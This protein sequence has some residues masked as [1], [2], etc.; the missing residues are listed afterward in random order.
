MNSR[1]RA[2]A[3]LKGLPVD[4]VP[5]FYWLNPHATCQMIAE[6]QPA[7]S[8]VANWLARRL[9]RRFKKQ[10][11]LD[12]GEWTRAW[13]LLFEE[14]GN[15]QYALQLGADVSIQ[16]P[17]LSSPTTFVTSVRKRGGRLTF[18]GPFDVT[19][20]MGGVY[21]FPLEP[22]VADARNLRH[23]E[24]PSITDAQFAGVRR[25]RNTHLDV[26]VAC[27]VFAFQ[28]VLCDY[29]LAMEPF[30]LALYDYP[31]EIAAFLGRL[32]DWVV[33]IIQH[34]ARTGADVLCFA[35]DYG[36]TGRP[37]ISMEMWK[38]FTYP[39]LKRF[40]AVAHEEGVPFMLHS[41]G[42]QMP[43]LEYYVEAELD[44]LQSF[45]PKAGND[46]AAAYAQYGDRLAFATGIDIQRGET[47]TPEELRQEILD[48]YAIGKSKGRFILGTTHMLQ[49][50]MPMENLQAIFR[51]VQE[52]QA[53]LHG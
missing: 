50:S 14:Y 45:Q 49:Y 28:Q 6:Y 34:A 10:G 19:L 43:F 3:A 46:L 15:G 29:I 1:E 7:H 38:T 9:W 51:T 2:L 48:N 41:C 39:H 42:Y 36:T 31:D 30:M 40:I 18:K 26:C 13:P 12:A 33:D 25:F 37:L 11:E 8:G 17:E 53:G 52:I 16:S 5:V 4:R 20:G 21:A 23:I 35:D 27:E 44:L 32:A 24:F 47:M 22:A